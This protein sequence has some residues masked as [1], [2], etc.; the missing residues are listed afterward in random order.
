MNTVTRD[1]DFDYHMK[2]LVA[3]PP[4]SNYD[5]VIAL[6][7]GRFIIEGYPSTFSDAEL[8]AQRNAGCEDVWK[9][10]AVAEF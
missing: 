3:N 10:L 7:E 2:D 5:M 6:T 1:I 4:H 8:F 9:A